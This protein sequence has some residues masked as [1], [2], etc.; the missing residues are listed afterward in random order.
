MVILTNASE[1]A[2]MG[3]LGTNRYQTVTDNAPGVQATNI[4]LLGGGRSAGRQGLVRL[5]VAD[6]SDGFAVG[7]R[8]AGASVGIAG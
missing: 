2:F 3:H 5:A 4:F 6:L 8:Y 7:G 1:E